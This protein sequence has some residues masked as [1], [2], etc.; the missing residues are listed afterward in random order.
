MDSVCVFPFPCES[1]VH[2]GVLSDHIL[3]SSAQKSNCINVLLAA[4]RKIQQ[5][6]KAIRAQRKKLSLLYNKKKF[7]SK[8]LDI[9]VTVAYSIIGGA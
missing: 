2:Q 5:R 7:N 8:G 6:W 1:K 3:P 4:L 9:T